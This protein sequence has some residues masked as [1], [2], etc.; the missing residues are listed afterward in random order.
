MITFV[1]PH[2]QGAFAGSELY[3]GNDVYLL[4]FLVAIFVYNGWVS[5]EVRQD[6]LARAFAAAEETDPEKNPATMN[7]LLNIVAVLTI[8]GL[9]QAG[10]RACEADFLARCAAFIKKGGIFGLHNATMVTKWIP[11]LPANEAVAEFAAVVH[12]SKNIRQS[13]RI[14]EVI[15]LDP[16]CFV[17]WRRGEWLQPPPE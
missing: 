10:E 16:Q 1:C 4:G 2:F 9:D 3:D 11:A 12:E 17:G 14:E 15:D 7:A 6:A 8:M 13:K 5:A